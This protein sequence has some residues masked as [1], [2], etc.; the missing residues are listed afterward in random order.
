MNTQEV[1]IAAR[2][3][4]SGC[5]PVHV[6]THKK[7]GTEALRTVEMNANGFFVIAAYPTGDTKGNSRYF[8]Y[9]EVRSI[10][11]AIRP[12]IPDDLPG[13]S[14]QAMP[15]T[16]F[17]VYWNGK[18]WYSTTPDP[19]V[20][21]YVRMDG[22]L[23]TFHDWRREAGLNE[24][25]D[26]VL[27]YDAILMKGTGYKD[28]L[29][30]QIYEGDMLFVTNVGKIGLVCGYGRGAYVQFANEAYSPTLAMMNEQVVF[31]EVVGWRVCKEN[32]E[33]DTGEV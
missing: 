1:E 24:T 29:D 9:R 30:R 18:M 31:V 12:G 11:Q 20:V 32:G 15:G 19:P 4:M 21:W 2:R 27:Y 8:K 33:I 16:P 25:Y 17:R 22:S 14:P 3:A 10:R 23:G 5:Y 6:D 13:F 7:L 28:I 26:P